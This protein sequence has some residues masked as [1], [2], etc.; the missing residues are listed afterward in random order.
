MWLDLA[1]FAYSQSAEPLKTV[2]PVNLDAATGNITVGSTT[3]LGRSPGLHLLALNRKPN[4]QNPGNLDLIR[5]DWFVESGEA[6]TANQWI[7]SV[8][9]NNSDA[10]LI[11]NAVGDYGFG[12]NSIA[13]NLEQFGATPDIEGV[14][15]AIPFVFIGNGGLNTGGAHQRGYSSQNL[16][17]YLAQDTNGKYTFIQ[18][19]YIKYD[20]GLDGTIKIGPTTYTVASSY[21]YA[22]CNGSNALHL[23]VVNRETPSVLIANNTYCTGQSDS[24]I[25]HLIQ[26]LQGV[27]G[28]EEQLVFFASNGHPIP[29]NWSF[30]TDG[31][32]RIVPL[33]RIM[34]QF[35]GYWET[36]VYLTPNDTYS[37]VGATAPP[38]GTLGARKRAR[39]ASSVY[40][41]HPTGELHGALGRGRRGNWYQPIN[42]DFS[43]RAN[44]A[45]Y[46]ILGQ[47]ST[48]FP[49]PANAAELQAFNQISTALCG[50]GCNIRNQYPDTNVNIAGL[51]AQLGGLRDGNN[52][53]CTLSNNQ[54]IPYCIVK[55]Q[56]QTELGYVADIRNFNANLQ[57][58]WLAGGS[59]S[60]SELLSAYT[61]IQG[62]ISA[63]GQAQAPDITDPLVSF[64]LSLASFIPEVGPAFGLADTAFSLAT[65]LTTDSSG[66]PVAT[67][68]TTV[69]NLHQQASDNFTAQANTIG[70]QFVEW[71]PKLRQIVKTHF[72]LKGKFELWGC[73][74][75]SSRKNLS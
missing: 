23:V 57:T 15:G 59:V 38:A 33:A 19:D 46:Q 72:S 13:K 74:V 55:Q 29:V 69:S 63:P 18:T 4:P 71:S 27:L 34:R 11:V 6:D 61:D 58:L 56:L 12:L 37:L 16:T 43:G 24:D 45:F 70:T 31:D 8:L 51:L 32:P 48:S 36:M 73:L 60:I 52:D 49:H 47:P 35:G 9:A 3:Y 7:T 53:D 26:D 50:A 42:A 10:I 25:S 39:E 1:P 22:G 40:P 28:H 2:V 68:Y 65:S 20:I 14:P 17:G 67:L 62:Q 54:S 66:N 30:G 41:D 64:F 75:G 21:R 5:N 44:L